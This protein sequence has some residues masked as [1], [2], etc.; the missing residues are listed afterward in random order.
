MYTIKK[1]LVILLVTAMILS[2]LSAGFSS[3]AQGTVPTEAELVTEALLDVGLDANIISEDLLDPILS[4][5]IGNIDLFHAHLL[6][7]GFAPDE[8]GTLVPIFITFIQLIALANITD[9]LVALLLTPVPEEEALIA[10]LDASF[11]HTTA[12]RTLIAM[13]PSVLVYCRMIVSALQTEFEL[14]LSPAEMAIY[15]ESSVRAILACYLQNLEQFNPVSAESGEEEMIYTF[16]APLE[17]TMG[18]NVYAVKYTILPPILDCGF[19]DLDAL[20][21]YMIEAD[22]DA[23]DADDAIDA[24]LYAIGDDASVAADLAAWFMT[25]PGSFVADPLDAAALGLSEEALTLIVECYQGKVAAA[26]E[27]FAFVVSGDVNTA[28]ALP[29][30]LQ[31][32][33]E[34]YMNNL[35][36]LNG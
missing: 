25:P 35:E 5:N 33:L 19:A 4:Q 15:F 14:A 10:A 8:V 23:S 12:S 2:A 6:N 27:A 3:F 9:N 13:M 30:L 31:M 34:S 36:A 7:D 20:R 28:A 16:F 29:M 11:S 18:F 17:A 1:S 24:L 22:M 26:E 32:L 21:T